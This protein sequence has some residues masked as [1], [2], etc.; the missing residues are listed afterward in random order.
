M[1]QRPT[2]PHSWPISDWPADVYPNDP[3]KARYTVRA[4]KDDL[5]RMGAL[6]RVGRELVSQSQTRKAQRLH[7]PGLR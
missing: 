3:K 2:L 4:H 7:P 6:V 1:A 5:H